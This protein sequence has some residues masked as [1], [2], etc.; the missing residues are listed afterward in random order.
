[1]IDITCMVTKYEP[2]KEILPEMGGG[3]ITPQNPTGQHP[4]PPPDNGSPGTHS[5]PIIAMSSDPAQIHAD[6]QSSWDHYHPIGM[7]HVPPN[8][9]GDVGLWVGYC[10]HIDA[11]SGFSNGK[12]YLGWNLYWES[13]MASKATSAYDTGAGNPEDASL[14]AIY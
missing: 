4:L 2:E 13:R 6:V 7:A 5:N 3:L 9:I 8:E 14:P 12:F 10:D 11:T 1:M